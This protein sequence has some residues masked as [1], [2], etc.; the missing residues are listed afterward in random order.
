MVWWDFCSKKNIPNVRFLRIPIDMIENFFIGKE[1]SGIWI[2]FPDP[3]IK[4]E[5]KRLTSPRFLESYKKILHPNSFIYF[6][7]DNTI[8]FE[9]TLK[10][11]QS[12]HIQS[13]E[14]TFDLYSSPL[15]E[16]HFG[17]QTNYEKIFIAKGEKIKYLKFQFQ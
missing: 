2:T 1:V 4:K 9:Y 8:L 5:R 17:I 12:Q 6:K 7:T 10:V 15:L 14:Y 3:Y 11:L 13:L 16:E